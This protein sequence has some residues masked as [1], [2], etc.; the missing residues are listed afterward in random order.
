VRSEWREIG[1]HGRGGF[2]GL[3]VRNRLDAALELGD[4]KA[5]LS[6]MTLQ[7]LEQPLPICVREAHEV[8][9]VRSTFTAVP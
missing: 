7:R 4:V 5:A 6:G 1:H 3:G 2:V 9:G 8:Q